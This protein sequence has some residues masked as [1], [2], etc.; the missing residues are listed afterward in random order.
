MDCKV[1]KQ[2]F[3]IESVK[4][5]CNKVCCNNDTC[6]YWDLFQTPKPD[7]K[8][9]EELLQEWQ[10]KKTRA[11]CV[12]SCSMFFINQVSNI[13]SQYFVKK[14][15]KFVEEKVKK[16]IDLGTQSEDYNYILMSC[17]TGFGS[18][19]VKTLNIFS[20]SKPAMETCE[21]LYRGGTEFAVDTLKKAVGDYNNNKN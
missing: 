12:E 19:S 1:K 16:T 4:A 2:L 20:Q 14:G 8:N 17:F 13:A 7:G 11:S 5:R 18:D 21:A 3:T 6:Q 10:K 9:K 15:I